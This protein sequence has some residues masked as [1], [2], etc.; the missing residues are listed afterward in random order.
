MSI[1]L[2]NK[3]ILHIMNFFLLIFIFLLIFKYKNSD[4]YYSGFYKNFIIYLSL[5]FVFNI[6]ITFQ[7][8]EEVRKIYNIFLISIIASFYSIEIYL[9]V[10]VKPHAAIEDLQFRKEQADKL[11]LPFDT[12]TKYEVY[13]EIKSKGIKVVPTV[14]P[15]DIFHK[16]KTFFNEISSPIYP[17][18]NI[19]NVTT[20]FC[21]ESGKRTIYFSDKYGFR[22][23]NDVWDKSEIDIVILGDSLVH[24]ACVDDEYVISSQLQSITGKNVLN[25]GIQGHGPLMQIAAIKEYAY[26]KKPK[27]V[28]WYYS[29][30]N[31]LSN[32]I[33]EMS[34]DKIKK[35][36][37]KN[38]SQKLMDN[39][40][41]ID[42][43][44]YSLI[45]LV[46]PTEAGDKGEKIEKI[47]YIGLLKL[48][49]LRDFLNYFVPENKAL[50]RYKYAPI[51]TLDEY[52]AL[53]KIAKETTE[54]WGGKFYFVYHPHLT[55]YIGTYS[56]QY[57]QRQY[58]Y[59]LKKLKKMNVKIIDL[60]KNLFD[61]VG[62]PKELYHFGI[63]GHPSENGYKLTAE[64]FAE[65]LLINK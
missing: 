54:E 49:K 38:Y 42:N 11:N 7:N 8:S 25:L 48:Y 13:N 33:Y 16:T 27:I 44:L 12:R 10:T 18:A 26:I 9:N 40:E 21:N 3:K 22:N 2:I 65:V 36:K 61:K 55:R 43:Q 50:I 46:S 20:V 57:G 59:F 24:G 41:L 32:M 58:N 56:L 52:F 62:H 29:E 64:Y 45:N 37:E 53:V 15:N 34:I 51:K 30:A 28:L 31:D 35:Y 14:P 60:K 63:P 5:F 6:I 47:N 39:Q 23:K 1:K 17:I 4:I 19:S